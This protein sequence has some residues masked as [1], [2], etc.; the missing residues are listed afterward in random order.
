MY[1][2]S[3]TEGVW[4]KLLSEHILQALAVSDRFMIQLQLSR[5]SI[6]NEQPKLQG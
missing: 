2:S 4:T 3:Y 1:C 5:M 6:F